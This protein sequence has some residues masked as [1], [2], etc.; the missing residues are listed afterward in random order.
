MP[1]VLVLALLLLFALNLAVG[2]LLD[3]AQGPSEPFGATRT[4]RRR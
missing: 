4:R 1:L 3:A 2:T